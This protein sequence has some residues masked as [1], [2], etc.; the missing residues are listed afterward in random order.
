MLIAMSPHR[1]RATVAL[2]ALLFGTSGVVTRAIPNRLTVWQ[3]SSAR[4]AV[5][6]LGLL[7]ASVYHDGVAGIRRRSTPSVVTRRQLAIAGAAVLGLQVGYFGAVARM[8]VAAATV[9][10][11][12]AG[13]IV[14]G[15]DDR[16]RCGSALPRRWTI[17]VATSLAGITLMGGG[18]WRVD[19]AGW[20]LA[21]AGGAC[22]PVYGA[23]TR[24]LMADR[25]PV[26]AMATVFAAAAPGALT[27][28]VLGSTHG[29]WLLGWGEV[30]VL[31]WVGL[32]AT[33]FAYVAWSIG[34][35]GLTVRDTVVTTMLEP[36][37]ATV[38]AAI[39]LGEPLPWPGRLGML[40]VVAGIVLASLSSEPSRTPRA[41]AARSAR[42][43]PWGRPDRMR[44]DPIHP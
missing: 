15:L 12:S 33:A 11:I 36:V 35:A 13:P 14:V 17:G 31:A 28:G 41:R 23:T 19:A 5:G 16:L 7:I 29:G 4:I 10:T 1:S 26:A 38:L 3:I 30:V 8:G 21:I 24:A 22:L 18:G 42:A 43:V 34:L 32:V 2:A 20:A 40:A 25:S 27:I 9:L 44:S 39:V 37:T 6:A